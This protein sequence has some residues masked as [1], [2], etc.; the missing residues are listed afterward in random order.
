MKNIK[1]QEVK[2]IISL[3]RWFEEYQPEDLVQIERILTGLR[4]I[5][6][7]VMENDLKQDMYRNIKLIKEKK[8]TQSL[9]NIAIKYF[10]I[11]SNNRYNKK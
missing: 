9:L 5:D 7:D 2:N 6:K 4:Y 1:K 10:C 8:H 3:I 11:E